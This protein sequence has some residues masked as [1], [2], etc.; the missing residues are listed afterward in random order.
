MRDTN[1]YS[2]FVVHP[3]Y[4]QY[5]HETGFNPDRNSGVD[6]HLHWHSPIN[7][8]VPDTAIRANLAKQTPATVPVTHYYD[9][10]RQC[11]DCGR[12]FLF[13]AREQKHWYEELGFGIDSD[14]VR[15]PE[16]RKQQQRAGRL[17]RRYEELFHVANRSTEQNLEMAEACLTLIEWS[18]F[19]ERQVSRVR[20]LL[21]RVA[22]VEGTV[23]TRHAA[24]LDRLSRFES[25]G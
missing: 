10:V 5:P 6:V 8:R 9:V 15:C 4:G 16:C 13:F 12:P 7:C 1:N 23:S 3:R 11:R 17:R 19:H 14:C 25:R 22:A 21:N 20:M 2:T 24:I 18:A